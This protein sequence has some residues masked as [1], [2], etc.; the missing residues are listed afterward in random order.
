MISALALV[1]ILSASQFAAEVQSDGAR[2]A[3]AGLA[4]GG[5]WQRALDAI[6]S[7]AP[8]WIALAPDLARGAD[9]ATAPQVGQALARALPLVPI[10]VLAVADLQRRPGVGI[11][12]VCGAPFAGMAPAERVRYLA[13]AREAVNAVPPLAGGRARE[14]C[15]KELAEA[16][17]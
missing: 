3:V 8:D 10:E 6:A 9:A 17:H 12:W 5:D 2:A 7:G 14:L 16:G 11:Q 15:L 4:A 1:A 13:D